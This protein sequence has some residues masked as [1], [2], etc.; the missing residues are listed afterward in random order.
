MP[1][2]VLDNPRQFA[3]V[4]GSVFNRGYVFEQAIADGWLRYDESTPKSVGA[5]VIM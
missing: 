4:M 2:K 3:D 5:Y 1:S